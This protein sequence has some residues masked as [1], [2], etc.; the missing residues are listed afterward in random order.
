MSDFRALLLTD[1]VDS[2]RLARQL[3]DLAIA[4]LW[5]RHDRLARDLLAPRRGREID[6][7]DGMLLIFETAAEAVDYALAYQRALAGMV[8]P[9]QARVGLHVGL[10]T[11]R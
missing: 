2:T 5:A 10:V 4:E 8:P 11:L 6:K 7:A 9:L 3:G 1:L